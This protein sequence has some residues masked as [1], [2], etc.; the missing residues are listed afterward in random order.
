MKN[1]MSEEL[2]KQLLDKM[3]SLEGR[4]R[5]L[6][7]R[8]DGV[9]GNPDPSYWQTTQTQRLTGGAVVKCPAFCACNN[10]DTSHGQ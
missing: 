5:N 1:L 10:C 8:H 2:L 7:H 9:N 6:E 3:A 4:L